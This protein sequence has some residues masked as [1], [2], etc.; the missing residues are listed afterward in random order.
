MSGYSHS[1]HASIESLFMACQGSYYY[2][3]QNSQLGKTDGYSSPLV[4][5]IASSSPMKTDQ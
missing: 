1:I 4:G 3:T 5:C 2:G